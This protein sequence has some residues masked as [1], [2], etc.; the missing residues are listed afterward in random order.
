MNRKH[1]V[2]AGLLVLAGLALAGC[3]AAPEEPAVQPG[4]VT[5]DVELIEIKGA[6]D[7]ISAPSDNPAELSTGYRFTPPGDFDA[8][9]PD[10]WQVSTY[11]F[12]PGALSVFQGDAVTLRMFGVNGDEHVLSL[13]AP[14][15]STIATETINRGREV[16]ITFDA[17]QAGYYELICANHAPTMQTPIQ[18]VPT[19]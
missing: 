11:M 12:S 6:T 3:G 2:I 8:E 19:G 10:K 17:D 15:G 18:V 13:V 4:S 5:F 1:L 7:G 14:D 9:N 16:E